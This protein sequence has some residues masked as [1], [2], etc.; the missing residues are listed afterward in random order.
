MKG[1]YDNKPP[2]G[3][4][5][6]KANLSYMTEQQKPIRRKVALKIIEWA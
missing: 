1:C 3:A 4:R 2:C 5:K 6:N